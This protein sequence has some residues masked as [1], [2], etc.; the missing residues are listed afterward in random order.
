MLI[1]LV[2]FIIISA[3]LSFLLFLRI[4][5]NKSLARQIHELAKLDSN[6]L[7]H[8]SY[9]ADDITKLAKEKPSIPATK[10][11]TT[12]DIIKVKIKL[13]I[14]ICLRTN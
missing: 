3:L 4:K 12:N 1:L 6:S 14:I 8:T 10:K 11:I 2:I 5:E 7:V 9:S 13:A